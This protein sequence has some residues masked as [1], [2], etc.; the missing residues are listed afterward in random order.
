MAGVVFVHLLAC[1]RELLVRDMKALTRSTHALDALV[2]LHLLP[3]QG[4][5]VAR[6][7]EQL[8]RLTHSLYRRVELVRRVG[9]DVF[10]LASLREGVHD[11]EH[12]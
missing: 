8:T 5:A 1:L 10:V 7:V 9:H 2:L 11:A 4:E 3:C 12:A 6:L